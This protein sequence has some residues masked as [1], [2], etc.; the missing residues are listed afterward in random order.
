MADE[1]MVDQESCRA[2]WYNDDCVR[3]VPFKDM[4]KFVGKCNLSVDNHFY[5]EKSNSTGLYCMLYKLDEANTSDMILPIIIFLVL[6]ILI[7]VMCIMNVR[8]RSG[9]MKQY[10]SSAH[11]KELHGGGTDATKSY[12][13]PQQNFTCGGLT[14]QFQMS[15][16]L[17]SDHN[18]AEKPAAASGEAD[19]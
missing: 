8:E 4:D 6:C 13:V 2:Y 7:L 1:I 19:I 15:S 3:M 17:K 16:N 5:E 14:I 9:I 18:Q 10:K 11:Y 12:R